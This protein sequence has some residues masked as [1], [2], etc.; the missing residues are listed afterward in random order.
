MLVQENKKMPIKRHPYNS[1]RK[2]GLSATDNRFARWY[3]TMSGTRRTVAVGVLI[4]CLV[5]FIVAVSSDLFQRVAVGALQPFLRTGA[6]VENRV[7]VAVKSFMPLSAVE[8]DMLRE[9]QVKVQEQRLRLIAAESA[10]V[11][12]RQLREMFDLPAPDGW[13][14]VVAPIVLRDPISWNRRLR[15]GKGSDH[16]IVLGAAVLDGDKVVGRVVEVSRQSAVVA[17]VLDV[18]C[19]LSVKLGDDVGVGVLRGGDNDGFN[20]S[21]AHFFT[22]DLLPKDGRYKVGQPVF[23]SG[24]S[25]VVP[26]GFR[27]G[28]LVA[29]DDARV[30]R[31]IDSSYARVNVKP[32]SDLKNCRFLAILVPVS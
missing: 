4:G 12:N 29:D 3:G 18:E 1:S 32:A 2:S 31:I 15:L 11:E 28:F 5:I 14:S 16:G 24:L 10:M 30:A 8:R 27:V 9:L 20:N 13:R 26:A 17:T 6:W 22:V 19:R 21:S 23:T 7:A 25:G